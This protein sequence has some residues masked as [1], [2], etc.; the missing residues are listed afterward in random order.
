MTLALQI[1]KDNSLLSDIRTQFQDNIQ[2]QIDL[3]SLDKNPLL[4]SMYAETLRFGV[5]IHIP[6]TSP[7]T[8]LRIGTKLIPKD[9]MI[10]VNTWLAHTDEDVWNTRDGKYPLDQ[11][12]PQ[13][14]MLDPDDPSSGPVRKASQIR[15]QPSSPSEDAPPAPSR[16]STDGLEGAWIPF[17]GELLNALFP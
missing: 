15:H 7:C 4:L 1:Q 5:Q 17:G 9:K 2:N 3:E 10:L 11:F 13:R 14:F 12:W 16:F 8:N 6:R